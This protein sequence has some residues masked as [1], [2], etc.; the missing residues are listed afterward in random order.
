MPP[1]RLLSHTALILSH[2]VS[3][4][5]KQS[6]Y[7]LWKTGLLSWK[8]NS[9]YILLQ[10]LLQPETSTTNAVPLS[11]AMN[12]SVVS[13]PCCYCCLLATTTT[14]CCNC[15]THATKTSQKSSKCCPDI[16][17]DSIT[18]FYLVIKSAIC[19]TF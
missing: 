16:K 5:F 18:F 13:T 11:V 1:N 4:S 7:L 14:D 6:G 3:Y 12:S 15:L 17:Y 19:Q 8:T 9:V 10:W 2:T